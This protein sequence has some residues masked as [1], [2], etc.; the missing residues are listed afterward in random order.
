[1]AQGAE[2][3]RAKEYQHNEQARAAL[4]YSSKKPTRQDPSHKQGSKQQTETTK[5]H[6]DL[7]NRGGL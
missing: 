2:T 4:N 1:M 6:G 5:E 7:A 3:I